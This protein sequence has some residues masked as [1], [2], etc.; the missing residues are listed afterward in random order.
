[1]TD[2]KDDD[3][4]PRLGRRRMLARLG[5]AAGA[6]Y[7]APVMLSLSPARASTSGPSRGSRSSGPSWASGP[8]RPRSGGGGGG[9]GVHHN[10]SFPSGFSCPS[11]PRVG[12]GQICHPWLNRI[13]GRG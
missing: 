10:Y 9:G 4:G 1:M 12:T 8:S 6:I 5:L 11:R 7:A 13:L 3:D 2:G